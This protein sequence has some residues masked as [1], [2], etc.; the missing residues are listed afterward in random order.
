MRVTFKRELNAERASVTRVKF[1]GVE[2]GTILFPTV[3][4]AKPTWTVLKNEERS[5][6]NPNGFSA[7]VANLEARSELAVR[8][9]IVENLD[10]WVDAEFKN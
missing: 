1:D 9:W 7:T 5:P 10:R 6:S 8:V 2:V 4:Q 3:W